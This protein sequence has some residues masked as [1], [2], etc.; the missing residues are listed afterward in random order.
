MPG[1][2]LPP[3]DE[4]SRA[5]F[6]A[7]RDGVWIVDADARIVEVNEGLC[8]MTGF[9]AEEL[10]GSGPPRCYWPEEEYDPIT[11]AVRTSMT[12]GTG[13]YE[14]YFKRKNGERFP[15][16]VNTS[17]LGDRGGFLCVARDLT[18]EQRARQRL[19]EAQAVARLASWEWN[20]DTDAM[21]ISRD[22]ADLAGLP[23]D[24]SPTLDQV[25]DFTPAPYAQR[26]RETFGALLSGA[27]DEA[28]FETPWRV[29]NPEIQWIEVRARPLRDAEGRVV[30]L[31]GTTQ[32]IT[33]RKLAELAYKRSEER[34]RQAQR[35]ADIGSFEVDYRTG[36]VT[37]SDELYRLYG[38]ERTE[39]SHALE[40]ARRLVPEGDREEI[41]RI[42][43]QTVQDGQPRQLTH[44][45]LRGGETRWGESRFEPLTEEGNRYGVRGTLQDIT[46]GKRAEQRIHLQAHL[47]D[48]VD[49]AV[50]A[51]ALDGTISYW[52]TGAQRTYGWTAEEVLG[53]KLRDVAGAVGDGEIAANIVDR[54]V[55]A[56]QW[57]GE[58]EVAGKNGVRF[59]AYL[60]MARFFDA[61]G[62]P[63]GVVTMSVDISQ[64][65]E[66]ERQLKA[67]RDYMRTV[68]DSMGEGLFTLDLEGRLTYLNRSGA[69]LLGWRPEE[70]LGQAMHDKTHYRRPDGSP[71]LASECPLVHAREQANLVRLDQDMF[72]R[73]DG[74]ELPVEITSSPFETEDGV[75]GS[76]VVFND[77]S[78]RL[79][80]EQRMREEMDALTW[81]ARI[82]DALAEDRFVLYAQP[83]I[84]VQSGL[85]VQHELLLRMIDV[86]GSIIPPGAFLPAAE[87][88]GLIVEVDRWVMSRAIGLAAE[89]HAIE[90]NL[91][92][93]SLS[94]PGL[95]DDFRSELLRTGADPSLIVVELTETALLEDEDAAALF[96][97]R[98]GALGCQLALDDFGTGYGGFRYLKSLPVDLLKIDMDFVRDLPTNQASQ[99]VVK[100]VV[101]LARDFDQRTV[102]E[103]VEDEETL[104]L[105][106]DFGVD[107][108]QGYAIARP[109][110]VH[111]VLGTAARQ[112]EP[113]GRP[114]GAR[115]EAHAPARPPLG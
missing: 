22:F 31:R 79:A 15:V 26:D 63:A 87:E 86:D 112:S 90:L 59:P 95:I 49:A 106:S 52:N 33:A 111:E 23:T 84:D 73:K 82:R 4:R 66:G 94:A 64:R 89:G 46:E 12:G 108:A 68:T 1:S 18:G 19:E 109:M 76:V 104:R 51:I 35:M 34:L 56:G 3:P 100:A 41:Q 5:L 37:W 75:R 13:Y 38:I 55:V 83:I 20:P 11:A 29:P 7:L 16:A 32:D 85:T 25:L 61:D 113:A 114:G 101:S 74:T 17:P 93:C 6:A 42:A 110:P 9:T 27:Q 72:I 115:L 103:G 96:I 71:C 97:E 60:R 44:R 47:L 98:I 88:Y 53:R 30:R 78:E 28:V 54:V 80:A 14:V 105:L 48:A 99:H 81:V 8:E 50:V 24:V 39:F 21:E 91:S 36:E 70:L 69:N 40:A 92:A 65:V 77:I 57:E 107:Y 45:Y 2:P 10:V 58:F 67:A 102:A 43:E 62:Q